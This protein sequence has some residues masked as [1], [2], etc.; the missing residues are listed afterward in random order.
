MTL[1]ISHWQGRLGNNILQLLRAI[2]LSIQ[3]KDG[4]IVF[5]PHNMLTITQIETSK[6]RENNKTIDTFFNLK[7]FGLDDV[8]P[9]IFKELFTQYI[10]PI[11]KVKNSSQ[12]SNNGLYIH[13]RSGD[14]FSSMPHPAYVPP[15]LYYYKKISKN[16]NE[17]TI[18][19]EDEKHPCTNE[20]EKISNI[21]MS[22]NSLENDI[23]TLST[24]EN[25]A[26]GFGTFGF[27]IYL[28]NPNLKKL[29]I[30]R[31]CLDELPKGNW[32]NDIVL[33]IIDLPN[34]IKVGEW[35]NTAEQRKRMLEYS[36][37]KL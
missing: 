24:A 7:K 10:K 6:I 30:P 14:T 2:V 17:V 21:K 22:Y 31:Y 36:I 34:Y 15:P 20:M 1:L 18:I 32:G 29:F 5:P 4:L 25:L 13:L 27:L 9:Y 8:E 16:F 3:K 33:S 35:K 23:I 26:I 12:S 28:I 37:V 19:A 11:F